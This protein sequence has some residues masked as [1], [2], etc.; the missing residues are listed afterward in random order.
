[1]KEN[2]YIWDDLIWF[3]ESIWC[4]IR[5]LN[6]HNNVVS[7]NILDIDICDDKYYIKNVD[8]EVVKWKWLLKIFKNWTENIYSL[9]SNKILFKKW[10]EDIRISKVRYNKVIYNFIVLDDNK[11]FLSDFN[12]KIISKGYDNISL[13]D[14]FL[15]NILS[16]SLNDEFNFIN[17]KWEVLSDIW[18]DDYEDFT[19]KEFTKIVKWESIN[20]L[21]KTWRVLSNIWFD[22]LIHLNEGYAIIEV[23]NNEIIFWDY[24]EFEYKKN[25]LDNKYFQSEIMYNDY[26]NDKEFIAFF[27]YLD[28][29]MAKSYN[30]PHNWMRDYTL[31]FN[32]IWKAITNLIFILDN[33]EPYKNIYS[34]INSKTFENKY[35]DK[36]VWRR[37]ALL[38]SAI[39]YLIES[40]E[41]LKNRH[42]S[43]KYYN[44]CLVY[45]DSFFQDLLQYYKDEGYWKY[46]WD[47]QEDYILWE[48]MYDVVYWDNIYLSY[49]EWE[50][51]QFCTWWYLNCLKK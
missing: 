33:Y 35:H 22:K 49:W 20:Y 30:W 21:S 14:S 39:Y 6:I 23:D 48:L 37:E 40:N 24:W 19:Y 17:T 29:Y 4:E 38:S 28:Y 45:M 43:K 42:D 50:W 32:D 15:N 9:D 34:F 51:S 12:G 44:L 3:K 27:V 26:E 18:F 1:M 7:E 8:W 36:I 46:W 5:F 13:W 10:Y 2:I 25:I 31:W 47:K 11:Y 16:I 41:E